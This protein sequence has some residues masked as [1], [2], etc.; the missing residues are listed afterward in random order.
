[1][2]RSY[3]P[4]TAHRARLAFGGRSTRGATRDR[5]ADEQF[6]RHRRSYRVA[7]VLSVGVACAA[8]AGCVTDD[9]DRE[10]DGPD[11]DVAAAPLDASSAVRRPGR[12]S[13]YAQAAAREDAAGYSAVGLA[14]WEGRRLPRPPHRR[15]R[16]LRHTAPRSRPRTWTLPLGMHGARH[17]SRQ[18]PLAA[19]ARQRSRAVRRQPADRPVG[20]ERQGPRLLRSR[21]RPRE[22]RRV[23]R[24]RAGRAARHSRRG[25]AAARSGWA[26][27]PAA[28]VR[29]H[30]HIGSHRAA[31]ARRAERAFERGAVPVAEIG[32]GVVGRL[33]E[34]QQRRVGVGAARTA[35]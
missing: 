23:R 12:R 34:R 11:A 29:G 31:L 24:R 22:G 21:R 20:A 27:A 18:P 6:V 17:Q 13:V 15:R 33:Q 30:E 9:T 25:A 8:L 7:H 32:G 4:F 19:G 14:S 16:D 10:A 5:G 35:S 26:S 3:L 1:M 2:R 28:R